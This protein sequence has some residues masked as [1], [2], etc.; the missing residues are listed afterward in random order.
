LITQRGREG[1]IEFLQQSLKAAQQQ[2]REANNNTKTKIDPESVQNN[3]LGHTLLSQPIETSFLSPRMGKFA[4]QLHK[5]GLKACKVTDASVEMVVTAANISH[6]LV[7]P[8]PEDCK[9]LVQQ[10]LTSSAKQKK[11]NGCLVLLRLSKPIH[12]QNK[13]VRQLCFPLPSDKKMGPI[14]PS[15]N[16]S[17]KIEASNSHDDPADDDCTQQWCNILQQ[18]LCGHGAVLARVE[19]HKKFQSFQ[20]SGTSTTSGGMPFVTCYMGVNDGVLYP[21]PEGLLFYKP[22]LFLPRSDLVSIACG[23]GSGG[24]GPNASRYVDMVVTMHPPEGNNDG[25]ETVI[26]FSNIQR[27]ENSVLNDYIQ[28]IL[29]P[30]MQGDAKNENSNI[31]GA[32]DGHHHNHEAAKAMADVDEEET[33]EEDD[34]EVQAEFVDDDDDDDDDEDFTDDE[35]DDDDD[36]VFGGDDGNDEEFTVVR[37]E[38]AANLVKEKRK[39]SDESS[40][41]TESGDNQPKPRVSKRLR[42]QGTQ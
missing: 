8:K 26:E 28:N 21:L 22:P 9:V 11:L 31:D 17:E 37:D 39:N 12:L 20:P 30:A 35:E 4:V 16:A 38:F 5:D 36:N 10:N 15:W 24:G 19:P 14:R 34:E 33:E 41:A 3:D 7:F 42:H 13:S 6:I 27:E 18:S 2:P 1:A 25:G 40:T 32:E 23:R 29:I